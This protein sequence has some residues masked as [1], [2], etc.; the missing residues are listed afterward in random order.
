MR[1]GKTVL[2]VQAFAT[3]LIGTAFFIQVIELNK[4]QVQELTI[5]LDKGILSKDTDVET[6]IVDIKHRYTVASYI[7]LIIGMIELLL[8]SRLFS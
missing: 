7:L 5:E 8:I 4:Q 6:L 3:L 1:W 2:L